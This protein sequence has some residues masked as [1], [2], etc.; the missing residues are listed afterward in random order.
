MGN[1]AYTV[2]TTAVCMIGHYNGKF[3][4]KTLTLSS[5]E[6]ILGSRMPSETPVK[7][8]FLSVLS[9]SLVLIIATLVLVTAFTAVTHARACAKLTGFPG[10]LQ[11]AGMLGL[12]GCVT[13]IGAP[14]CNGG[15]ICTTPDS[16]QGTCRNQAAVGQPVSCACSANTV[17]AGG[18]K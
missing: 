8:Q 6:L 17:S 7:K 11:R 12:T 10:L 14:V 1:K 15:A 4:E 13:K 16:K 18:L 3:T 5:A 9:S 2:C